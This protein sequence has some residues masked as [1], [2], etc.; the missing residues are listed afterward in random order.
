MMLDFGPDGV[1]GWLVD[2]QF[3]ATPVFD[4]EARAFHMAAGTVPLTRLEFGVMRYLV[5]GWARW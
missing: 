2:A 3:G 4:A 5:P 1:L